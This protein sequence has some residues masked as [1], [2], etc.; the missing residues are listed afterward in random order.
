[1]LH[2]LLHSFDG[3]FSLFWKTGMKHATGSQRQFTI[4]AIVFLV[5]FFIFLLGKGQRG[6]K[7]KRKRLIRQRYSTMHKQARQGVHEA[8]HSG[9]TFYDDYDNT[10]EDE[11]D[12]SSPDSGYGNFGYTKQDQIDYDPYDEPQNTQNTTDYDDLENESLLD[13]I[14]NLF[15]R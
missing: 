13:K 11:Y 7:A 1:M 14:R 4:L 12:K 9:K 6:M 10:P 15:R 8:R 3:L 2:K 5:V